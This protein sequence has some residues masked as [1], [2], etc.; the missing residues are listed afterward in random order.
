M[1]FVV[2]FQPTPIP[3]QPKSLYQEEASEEDA[4]ADLHHPGGVV[5][6]KK[7]FWTYGC[8]VCHGL[9]AIDLRGFVCLFSQEVAVLA[10]VEAQGEIAILAKEV[11][12][13]HLYLKVDLVTQEK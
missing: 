11:E 12:A 5:R 3:G 13:V 7:V 9:V 6:E 2:I 8:W 10:F 4:Q 1:F